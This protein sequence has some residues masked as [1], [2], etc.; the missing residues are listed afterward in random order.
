MLGA[1]RYSTVKQC[2]SN[3][4]SYPARVELCR[5]TIMI[6]IVL[7]IAWYCVVKQLNV[8]SRKV[9]WGYV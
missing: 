9:L 5:V 6:H 3:V 2:Y 4:L 7:G 8:K 1:V